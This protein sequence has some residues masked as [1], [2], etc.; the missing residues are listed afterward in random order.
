MAE[1]QN[2]PWNV[3]TVLTHLT[4]LIE[5][6]DRR[7]EQRFEASQQA[8]TLGFS[9]QK[10]AV[11]AALAAQNAAV[12]KAEMAAEKRFESVN[13]FRNTLADQQRNLMPRSEVDVLMRGIHDKLSTLEKAHDAVLAERQGLKGGYG[14][15]VGVVGFVL[16]ILAVIAG[17]ITLAGRIP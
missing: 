10:S 9:A 5:S 12:I 15:A 4:S 17:L 7:Y 3:E 13:E 8:I 16:T 1:N 2:G 11:D 14:Y 6:N